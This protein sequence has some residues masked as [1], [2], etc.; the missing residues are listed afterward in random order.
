MNL[1]SIVGKDS[2]GKLQATMLVEASYHEH[3]ADKANELWKEKGKAYS[4]I[5]VSQNLG[6]PNSWGSWVAFNF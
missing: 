1:Y 4:K 5:E 6:K 3:A 2:N